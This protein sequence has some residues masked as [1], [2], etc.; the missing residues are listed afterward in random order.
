VR[1]GY[2]GMENAIWNPVLQILQ[3]T[4]RALERDVAFARDLRRIDR[5]KTEAKVTSGIDG[6]SIVSRRLAGSMR[7]GKRIER[8][9]HKKNDGAL[10]GRG[11]QRAD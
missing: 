10:K 11:R 9:Q 8:S 7:K 2:E 6:D 4:R 3:K 5:T 1:K